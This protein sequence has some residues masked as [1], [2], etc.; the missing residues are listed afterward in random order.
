MKNLKSIAQWVL[1]P[2]F[3]LAVLSVQAEKTIYSLEY[4]NRKW[5]VEVEET[6]EDNVILIN[7]TVYEINP[8]SGDCLRTDS[9]GQPLGSANTVRLERNRGWT[10]SGIPFFIVK[11]SERYNT[12]FTA[13]AS[14]TFEGRCSVILARDTVRKMNPRSEVEYSILL[15]IGIIDICNVMRIEYLVR[16]RINQDRTQLMGTMSQTV[17]NNFREYEEKIKITADIETRAD[18]SFQL[19][20]LVSEN[21]NCDD[22]PRDFTL[23]LVRET[24]GSGEQITDTVQAED[25]STTEDVYTTYDCLPEAVEEDVDDSHEYFSPPETFESDEPDDSIPPNGEEPGACGAAYE[26]SACV[27][28]RRF[29]RHSSQ[30]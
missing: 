3:V 26:P 5:R 17:F 9:S 2:L 19:T 24:D 6:K 22:L 16:Y 8:I 18:G 29:N 7:T 10:Y 11:R 13:P 27:L 1:T 21:N 4:N 15:P 12:N 20:R 28:R 30:R 25:A 23:T 14:D